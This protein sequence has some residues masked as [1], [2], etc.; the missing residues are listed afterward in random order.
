MRTAQFEIDF[1]IE[2]AHRQTD[3]ATQECAG[4]EQAE[5]A[6]HRQRGRQP[7]QSNVWEQR[8]D[9]KPKT[10]PDEC[11]QGQIEQQAGA[12]DQARALPMAGDLRIEC[13]SRF[14]RIRF[15]DHDHLSQS[16]DDAGQTIVRRH[17]QRP[18]RVAWLAGRPVS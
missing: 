7:P 2:T 16:V 9:R 5:H 4:G 8:V 10:G 1:L 15:P 3:F 13:F 17:Q 14:R 11:R 12:Q 6:D 18:G